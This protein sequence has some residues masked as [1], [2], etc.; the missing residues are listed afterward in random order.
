MSKVKILFLSPEDPALRQMAE[1]RLKKTG[2]DLFTVGSAEGDPG[3]EHLKK[4]DLVVTLSKDIPPIPPFVRHVHWPVSLHETPQIIAGE[5]TLW[6]QEL[7]QTYRSPTT[8][9]EP[10]KDRSWGKYYQEEKTAW[11][12]G[13]PSPPFVR[14]FKEGKLKKGKMAVP[15]CGKGHEVLFFAKENF[16]VTAIDF[17]KEALQIVQ[18]RLQK[19][20]LEAKLLQKDFLDLDREED[21]RYD[22]ILEQTCYCAIEPVKRGNYVRA[23]HRLLRPQGELIALFYDIDNVD[24][25]P[26]GTSRDEILKRF[27]PFFKIESLEKSVFSH[28]RRKGKEWLGRFIKRV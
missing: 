1:G 12:L 25:P 13:E 26:F 28:E 5:I 24:G 3:H 23:A 6:I 9:K 7:I 20:S 11:D 19:A 18:E 16:E 2:A 22:Y 4:Y 15:G 17:A 8:Q 14:L 21:G 27:S 10:L